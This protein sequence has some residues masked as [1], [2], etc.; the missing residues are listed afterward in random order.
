MKRN[1]VVTLLGVIVFC[2]MMGLSM[3]P[4]AFAADVTLALG[5]PNWI[6]E[7]KFQLSNLK[8][9]AS[10]EIKTVVV[11]ISKGSLDKNINFT[12]GTIN[13]N[14]DGDMYTFIYNQKQSPADVEKLL[15]GLK[16]VYAEGQQV[17]ITLDANETKIPAD[18]T[19]TNGPNGHYYM[20]VP[21]PDSYDP[22]VNKDDMDWIKAYNDAKKTSYLGMK[23]YLATITTEFENQLLK[24]ISTQGAWSGGTRVLTSSNQ[25]IQDPSSLSLSALASTTPASKTEALAAFYWTC[26]PENGQAVNAAYTNWASGEPSSSY[27]GGEYESYMQINFGTSQ[28]WNDLSRNYTNGHVHGYFVEFGGYGKDDPGYTSDNTGEQI[29]SGSLQVQSF[30][31]E[32][33]NP[34]ASSANITNLP[35]NITLNKELAF[36]VIPNAGWTVGKEE[37]VIS[38]DGKNLPANA[39]TYVP[40]TGKVTVNGENI[41]GDIKVSINPKLAWYT[42]NNTALNQYLNCDKVTA[43]DFETLNKLKSEWAGLSDDAKNYVAKATGKSVSDITEKLEAMTKASQFAKDNASSIATVNGLKKL[44]P[45]TTN[46]VRNTIKDLDTK[47]DALETNSKAYLADLNT[48][49]D[50]LDA[51]QNFCDQY[52]N[53]YN[54][55]PVNKDTSKDLANLTANYEKLNAAQKALVKDTYDLLNDKAA[56]SNLLSK[57]DAVISPKPIINVNDD[58]RAVA[59]S[60]ESALKDYNALT[61]NQKNQL[62]PLVITD[63]N[64]CKLGGWNWRYFG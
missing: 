29:A 19:V 36:N 49:L 54:T 44:D 3:A 47:Y 13:K 24:K 61:D 2:L 43:A 30:K 60:F 51:A 17:S 23:G 37:L 52:K 20:Y 10:T 53:P 14:L 25:K 56:A 63:L 38:V 4:R 32:S 15:H 9:N 22:V 50:N 28:T 18:A 41:T 40:E 59:A 57:H 62:D 12:D 16:F 11:S 39:Y 42:S 35:T 34:Y 7:N 1:R 45:N 64:C 21:Y 5:N 55:K 8:I 6:S 26:G 48:Q 31:V 27:Y 33:A 46:E 58:A